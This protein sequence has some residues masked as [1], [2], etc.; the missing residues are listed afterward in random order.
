MKAFTCVCGAV[1]FG[2]LKNYVRA[3]K[4]VLSEQKLKNKLSMLS[5][6]MAGVMRAEIIKNAHFF[7]KRA[8]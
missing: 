6:M 2:L 7:L 4:F 8:G 3:F 5:S 1:V